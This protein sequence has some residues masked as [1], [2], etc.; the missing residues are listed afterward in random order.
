MSRLPLSVLVTT[1]DEAENLQACLDSVVWADDVLVVDSGSSDGTVEIARRAGAR[2]LAHP[3]ESAA[4]QKNWALPLVRHPWVLILDADE[5]VSPELAREIQAVLAA[6]GPA[7][8]YFLHRRSFF[9]GH[10][11]RHCGWDRDFILRFFRTARGRYDD[12]LVHETL[13]LDGRSAH[14]GGALW[15]Y[16]YRSFSD[17]LERLDRYTARGAAD[18]RAAGRRPSVAALL[19]RPP[20]RFLRMYL[21]QRGFLDGRV[22]LL[23]CTLAAYSV[24]LKYARLLE[25]DPGRAAA[26]E[27]L[28]TPHAAPAA[29]EVRQ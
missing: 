26:R 1:L 25:P 7:D 9:L 18:L 21:A 16:T 2:V 12:K 3:Y 11:V 5:R 19:L 20:G 22:G 28:L 27:T 8:G 10:A 13:G 17:Y 4:R 14:L 6:D 29:E 23:V 15:H 24:W